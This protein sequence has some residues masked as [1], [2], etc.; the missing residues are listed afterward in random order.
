M[1]RLEDKRIWLGGGGVI[2]LLIVVVAWFMFI[3]PERSS[4][5]DLNAQAAS[6]RQQNDVLQAKVHALQVKSQ[7]LSKYTSSLQ[8]ALEALPF[9]SGLP[10]F[11]RQLS[12]QG[13]ANSV[14]VSS[15]VVGGITS[16]GASAPAAAA[17][18][19]DS[20]S[21]APTTTTTTAPAAA[22][23]AGGLFSVAVTVQSS[24]TLTNQ[25]AFLKAIQTAG[26]RRA[27]VTSA[28]ITPGNGAKEASIDGVSSFT[29]SL[30]VFSAPQT[31]AQVAQLKTLLTGKIGN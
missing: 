9:D 31:P 23:V 5:D 2:G 29:T 4:A 18:A 28:Q 27:L 26:P 8:A 17:P 15:V 12:A 6:T 10:A 19:E 1:D 24:G 7:H 16:V 3:G 20:T 25:L 21:T 30:T 13:T 22:P 14:D 11:T